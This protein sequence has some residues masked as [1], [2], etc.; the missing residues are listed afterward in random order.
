MNGRTAF[1]L[2]QNINIDKLINS[3]NKDKAIPKP[4][5]CIHFND[6]YGECD[7]EVVLE[8]DG[9]KLFNYSFSTEKKEAER[10]LNDHY[11]L[12]TVS[13]THLTLPTIYSV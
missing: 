5:V 11:Y 10:V 3:L 13:Y 12:V 6:R 2:Q 7:K 1:F 9:L 4:N 8:D